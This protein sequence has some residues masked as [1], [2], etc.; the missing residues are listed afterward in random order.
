M[1]SYANQLKAGG[2]CGAD[3]QK[4]NPYVLQ[5]YDGFIA[6]DALYNAS[7]AKAANGSNCF[8]NALTDS[9]SD[10]SYVYYLP[11]GFSLPQGSKPTCNDCIKKTMDGWTAAATNVTTPIGAVYN[12]AVTQL[13]QVCGSNFVNQAVQPKKD[14]NAAPRATAAASLW[15]ISL[16]ATTA[17]WLF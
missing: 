11:L 14:P 10:S 15:A 17:W 6:Y 16:V 3:Y 2:T 4:Q 9:D 1:T 13:N 7:C 5:A 12:P 8:V